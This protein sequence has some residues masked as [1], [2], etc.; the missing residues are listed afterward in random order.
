MSNSIYAGTTGVV[1]DIEMVNIENALLV[2][3]Q[4]LYVRVPNSSEEEIWDCSVVEVG[5][6]IVF[7]HIIPS[8][9]TLVPGT[10]F[11]QPY[12]EYGMWK[13]RTSTVRRNVLKHFM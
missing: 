7:R 11:I 2:Q 8:T 9:Y 13:G 4:K 6:T 5:E 3:N 10:Y 12:Y 1:L